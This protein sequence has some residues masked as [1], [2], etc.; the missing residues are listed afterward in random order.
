MKI[1]NLTTKIGIYNSCLILVEHKLTSLEDEQEML[2]ETHVA[3]I[4]ETKRLKSEVN[5]LV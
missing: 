2:H 1:D 3:L 5:N 4:E